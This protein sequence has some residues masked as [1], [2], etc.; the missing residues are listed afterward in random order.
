MCVFQERVRC[1]GLEQQISRSPGT[2]LG[3]RA[4]IYGG[5]GAERKIGWRMILRKTHTAL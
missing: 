2:G 4:L 5:K 3:S 1:W